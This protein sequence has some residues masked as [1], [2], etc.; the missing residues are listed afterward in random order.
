AV[1]LGL[2]GLAGRA[3]GIG[4]DLRHDLAIAPYDVLDVRI[5]V[6]KEG[7]VAARLAV[8]FDE[9]VESLRL[10]RTIVDSMP[11][12]PVRVPL[13]EPPPHKVG[14]GYVEG[15][16]GPVFVALECGPDGSIRR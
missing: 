11:D 1:K 9:A 15:W 13:A 8:R 2:R 12:G 6:R 10:M 5:A 14:L 4:R 7:D 16:R 3:S